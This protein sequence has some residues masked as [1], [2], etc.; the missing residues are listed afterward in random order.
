MT[1]T[2][3]VTKN[4]SNSIP[5]EK[6]KSTKF[7]Q[8]I[9]FGFIFGFLLQKGGVAKYHILIG[10]LLLQDFTVIK[11]MMSAIIVG[12]VGVYF[13]NKFELIDLH[14][15]P[16]RLGSNIIGG[17]IFGVGFALIGYCPGTGAAAIGQGNGDAL[18]GLGGLLLGSYL[19]A[20]LSGKIKE[21]IEKWRDFGKITIPT[22]FKVPHG[23]VVLILCLLLLGFL[24]FVERTWP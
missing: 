22:L 11:V 5:K 8:A 21:T 13:L 15:K 18:F 19:F 6:P 9:I 1:N 17:L 2:E 24:F 10:Q 20:E 12:M 23:A 14:L 7:I 16:T 4:K 3:S